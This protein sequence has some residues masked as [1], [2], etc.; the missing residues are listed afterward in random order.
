[1]EQGI[2]FPLHLVDSHPSMPLNTHRARG[3]SEHDVQ[4]Q[5]DPTAGRLF[6]LEM[7]A[8][9]NVRAQQEEYLQ[10]F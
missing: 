8:L 1:M 6:S 4:N 7:G 3:S 2:I 10:T 9:D 5:A